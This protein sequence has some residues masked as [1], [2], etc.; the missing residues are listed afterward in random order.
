MQTSPRR[1]ISYPD[2]IRDDAPDIPLHIKNLV[3]KLDLDVPL[4]HGLA[5]AIPA[6]GSVVQG[7]LYWATD[8]LTLSFNTGAAW[9]TVGTGTLTGTAVDFSARSGGATA[10]KIGNAGPGSQSGISLQNGESYFYR[11]AANSV[12]LAGT[13]A[14]VL[15]LGTTAQNGSVYLYGQT[16]GA[17]K[18]QAFYQSD[19]NPRFTLATDGTVKWG[20]GGGTATDTTLSR[21]GVNILQVSGTLNAVTDLQINGNSVLTSLA[22]TPGTEIAYDQITAQVSPLGQS[23]GAASSIIAGTSKTYDGTPVM[24]EF[25]CP[26]VISS[27]SATA[28][29]VGLYL[30]GTLIAI[31][32]NPG[33]SDQEPVCAK[34]R[35]TPSAGAHTYSI[36]AY[37][38]GTSAAVVAG[39][40]AGGNMAPAYL[41]VTRA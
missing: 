31:I 41:R 4:Y 1:A 2:A 30:D 23:Q 19:A 7:S 27:G 32:A 35:H 17:L 28:I 25:D 16:T 26:Y 6:F 9:I 34:M 20:P 37:A 14:T 21:T 10:V 12:T 15:K 33:V 36:K 22:E 29:W 8:T 13:A 24:L 11:D 40:G 18:L 39:T 5:S 38:N 3:D